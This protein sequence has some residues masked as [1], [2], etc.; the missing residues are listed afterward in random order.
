MSVSTR[1]TLAVMAAGLA[2]AGWAYAGGGM[3]SSAG[4]SC[5]SGCGPKGH[6]VVVPGANVGAPTVSQGGIKGLSKGQQQVFVPGVNVA[7]AHVQV[8]A[9][10]IAVNGAG[11]AFG[12]KTFVDMELNV[13]VEQRTD[14]RQFISS[15]GFYDEAT[16]VAPS[17]I[18]GLNI[19]GNVETYSETIT[20]QVPTTQTSCVAQ[21]GYTT[22]WRPVQAV[23]VD[24]K[25]TP[26]PASRLSADQ[27]VD[28]NFDG[29]IFRCMAGTSM[30]V[31]LGDQ[32]QL[33]GGSASSRFQNTSGFSCAK[34]EA[35]VHRRGGRLVCQTQRPQ[36]DCNERSLLRRNG[37]G[38]KLVQMHA[39][40]ACVPTTTTVMQTV[41]RQVQR[42]RPAKTAPM[43]FDGGVGQSVN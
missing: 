3:G 25:G 41:Q 2:F 35:L 20:E 19:E 8:G 36:R 23:C 21:S 18:H 16:G 9:P 22:S 11:V 27:R 28:A 1:N 10:T 6:N 29:E 43:V 17:V 26:H 13:E 32:A 40:R 30:R 24:D 42:T 37:P 7:G 4:N 12:A 15:G 14:N 33:A 5:N 31:I 34:G 39:E 38:I